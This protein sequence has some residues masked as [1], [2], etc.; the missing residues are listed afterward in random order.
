M[1]THDAIL[2]DEYQLDSAS[3]PS[4][5]LIAAVNSNPTFRLPDDRQTPVLFVAGGCG[6]AP[7]RAFLEER[8]EMLQRAGSPSDYFGKGMLFLGFRTPG[9][10]I[11]SRLRLA[12]LTTQRVYSLDPRQVVIKVSCPSYRLMDVAEV[13][14]HT[15]LFRPQLTSLVRQMFLFFFLSNSA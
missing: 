12:G 10:A 2:D 1:G 15:S 8:L 11:W 6:V 14:P 3:P 7:I 4:S 5:N 9:T 13:L